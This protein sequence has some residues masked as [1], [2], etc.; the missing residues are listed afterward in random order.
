[1]RVCKTLSRTTQVYGRVTMFTLRSFVER[2]KNI[3][4]RYLC[5]GLEQL[6][7]KPVL[8]CMLHRADRESY[9]YEL[10]PA[11]HIVTI[12]ESR[13]VVAFDKP[14]VDNISHRSLLGAGFR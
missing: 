6:L 11:A 10:E 14:A 9:K 2:C 8:F 12:L 13:N 7:S 5:K 1:M 3:E 4:W